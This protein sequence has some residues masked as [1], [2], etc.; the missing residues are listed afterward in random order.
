MQSSSTYIHT[1]EPT[2]TFAS[3]PLV[4]ST[5]D[6]E[7][8]WKYHLSDIPTHVT[9]RLTSLG[10]LY[11]FIGLLSIGLEVGLWKSGLFR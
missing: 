6:I 9:S 1:P 4:Q 11:L 10:I 7:Q 2:V 3:P 5:V 8:R